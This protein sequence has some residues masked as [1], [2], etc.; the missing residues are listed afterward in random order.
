VSPLART[1][2]GK[3][4]GD[5]VPLGNAHVE[6]LQIQPLLMRPPACA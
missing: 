4:V 6:I 2:M 1:L 3:H 5:V